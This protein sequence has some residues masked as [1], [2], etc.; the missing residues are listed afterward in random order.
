MSDD[1]KPIWTRWWMIA[2]YVFV[3]LGILGNLVGDDEEPI[4]EAAAATTTSEPAATTTTE[5]TPTTT[6]STTT[7]ST[8]TTTTQPATTTT[9]LSA[10][11]LLVVW[12]TIFETSYVPIWQ[13][14]VPEVLEDEFYWLDSV[15][16]VTYDWDDH[17]ITLDVT[18][19]FEGVYSRDFDEWSSDTWDLYREF[20]RILWGATVEGLE[21]EVD[22]DWPDW[23]TWAPGITFSA[24]TGRLSVECPGHIIEGIRERQ[25]IQSDYEAECNVSN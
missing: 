23:P 25:V 22:P 3:G 16:R 4:A 24:N 13:T 6:S 21:G 10:E 5:S 17:V 15:D 2:I 9:P 11:E 14:D 12:K 18:V 19:S 20:G 8:T 7:T 1:K